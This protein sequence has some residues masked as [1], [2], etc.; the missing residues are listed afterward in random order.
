[1]IEYVYR[2]Y[3]VDRVAMISTVASFHARSAFRGGGAAHGPG[4][5]GESATS[6]PPHDFA[7]GAAAT[8]LAACLR[9]TLGL[10]ERAWH[11]SPWREI[12]GRPVRLPR[13]LGIHPGGS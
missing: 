13:H 2:A 12:D 5:R 11:E 7:A 6:R 8:E 1:M 4:R 3:G 10:A 9:G